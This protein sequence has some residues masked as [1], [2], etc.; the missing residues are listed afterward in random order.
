MIR[1]ATGI[2]KPRN[3]KVSYTPK[4]APKTVKLR[5]QVWSTSLMDIVTSSDIVHKL[6]TDGFL[7][8]TWTCCPHCGTKSITKDKQG[9][10]RCRLKACN[11]PFHP[12][13]GHLIFKTGH[14]CTP[15]QTQAG[16]LYNAVLGVLQSHTQKQFNVNKKVVSDIYRSWSQVRALDVS[17][18]QK[19]MTVGGNKTWTQVEADEV[20]VSKMRETPDNKKNKSLKAVSKKKLLQIVSK[21]KKNKKQVVKVRWNQFFGMMERGRPETLI[22][23]RM[24]SRV[25]GPRAPGPGPITKKWWL[26]VGNKYLKGRNIV[27]HTDGAKA[28]K[29]PIEG[30][31]HT[32]VVHK[33]KF[34]NGKWISPKFVKEV[35]ADLSGKETMLLAGTQF[36]DGWWRI[37]RAQLKTMNTSSP[38]HVWESVR[39]AQWRHWHQ[40]Q[41]LWLAA[42]EALNRLRK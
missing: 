32:V 9:G 25:T 12:T 29:A 8:T 6:R 10:G 21:K 2:T 31:R 4:T 20:T 1:R 33:K 34:V 22:V 40:G 7:P 39:A 36:I 14:G 17:I 41:D 30:V 28:Y 23:H 26:P 38:E 37:L 35:I 3:K 24:P 16:I 11:K 18:R 19:S 5:D 42:G 27:L 13:T 15:L